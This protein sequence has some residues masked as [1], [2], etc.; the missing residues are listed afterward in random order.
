MG[1][2]CAFKILVVCFH[3]NSVEVRMHYACRIS[4]LNVNM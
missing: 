1:L 3:M 4:I 2:I